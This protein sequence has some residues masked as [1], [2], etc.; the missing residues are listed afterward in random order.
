MARHRIPI[1]QSPRMPDDAVGS[2]T[3]GV[4]RGFLASLSASAVGE[5]SAGRFLLLLTL[6]MVAFTSTFPTACA[7]ATTVQLVVEVQLTDNAGADPNLTF[8]AVVPATKPVQV[9][10]TLLPPALDPVA[11]VR[12]AP[13]GEL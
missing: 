3:R 2:P 1:R 6:F 10:V 12:P 13:Q 7:G 5:W 8:V 4:A 11:G 9:T